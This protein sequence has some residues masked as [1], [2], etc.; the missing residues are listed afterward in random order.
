MTNVKHAFERL[1]IMSINLNYYLLT[2][3]SELEESG[4]NS[5]DEDIEDFSSFNEHNIFFG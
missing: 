4:S 1:F 3:L 5:S 2:K